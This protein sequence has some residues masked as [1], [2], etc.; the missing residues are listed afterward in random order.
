M[1]ACRFFSLALALVCPAL[2]LAQAQIASSDTVSSDD[3]SVGDGLQ[4]PSYGH[5]WMLD[6]W[7]GVQELV[8]LRQPPDQ[9][10]AH[11]LS[12]KLRHIV[13][14]KGEAAPIRIHETTP[15]IFMRGVSGDQSGET[16]AD[17]V[18]LRVNVR[19]EYRVAAKEASDAITSKG[20]KKGL[21]SPDV[22]ELTQRRMGTTDWYRLSTKQPLEQGEYVMVPWPG[23]PSAAL[24]EIYD[25]AIDLDAPENRQP[26]RSEADRGPQ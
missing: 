23:T 21:R 2:A 12:L 26:L 22:I 15:Q 20:E 7:K 11:N 4:L 25:F 24:E 5:V 9:G 17:F 18:I 6:T 19:G 1:I 13:E 8:Q 14:L 10:A 16:R 3:I